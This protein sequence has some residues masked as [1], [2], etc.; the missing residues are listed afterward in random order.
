[1]TLLI[2][3]MHDKGI[4]CMYNKAAIST[5][6]SHQYMYFSSHHVHD[7]LAATMCMIL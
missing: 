5:N 3:E 6:C 4:I 1:M 7:A 2:N